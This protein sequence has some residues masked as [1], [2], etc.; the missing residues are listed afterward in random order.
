MKSKRSLEKSADARLK[1]LHQKLLSMGKLVGEVVLMDGVVSL[2]RSV[3]DSYLGRRAE[4]R[5]K[6]MASLREN[7]AEV[8]QCF[9]EYNAYYTSLHTE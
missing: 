2:N 9:H 7:L 4:L 1:Q 8:T 5:R 3:P 6:A